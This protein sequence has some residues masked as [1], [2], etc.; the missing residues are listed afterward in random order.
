LLGHALVANSLDQLAPFLAGLFDGHHLAIG[1]RGVARENA[2][3]DRPV[4]DV[5]ESI[6]SN[7]TVVGEP[8]LEQFWS[9]N[10]SLS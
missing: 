9:R 8:A 4:L 7:S 2:R 1:D 10:P 6:G 3:F 5:S